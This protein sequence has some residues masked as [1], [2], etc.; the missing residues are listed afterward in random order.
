[1]NTHQT[2]KQ[3]RIRNFLI[4]KKMSNGYAD[5]VDTHGIP[6]LHKDIT[7]WENAPSAMLQD[8]I[9]VMSPLPLF[10]PNI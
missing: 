9:S 1:M 4:L 6:H 7:E 10:I 8:G 3:T 5:N 2:I